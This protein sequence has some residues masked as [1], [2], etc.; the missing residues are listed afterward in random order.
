MCASLKNEWPA[1][2]NE[3]WREAVIETQGRIG[4]GNGCGVCSC[5]AWEKKH[6]SHAPLFPHHASLQHVLSGDAAR[7]EAALFPSSRFMFVRS[8]NKTHFGDLLNARY[9]DTDADL[10]QYAVCRDLNGP[11]LW[12]PLIPSALQRLGN[13]IYAAQLQWLK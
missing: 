11:W 1:C 5:N 3:R 8:R 10:H 12:M 9:E 6:T 7:G 13:D 4:D 2:A